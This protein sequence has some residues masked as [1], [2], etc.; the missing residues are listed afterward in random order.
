MSKLR[1]VPTKW[2]RSLITR[3]MLFRIL[4]FKMIYILCKGCCFIWGPKPIISLRSFLFYWFL[5]CSVSHISF[6][7]L[8]TYC[9]FC[10]N[11]SQLS[12]FVRVLP[13]CWVKSRLF[14]ERWHYISIIWL[15]HF[16]P[17]KN[18]LRLYKEPVV[19]MLARWGQVNRISCT[20][21]L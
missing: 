9:S 18:I 14:F 12:I 11:R 2:E 8:A 15:W 17:W 10:E 20:P 16:W 19:I 5:T 6:S 7:S 3:F 4:S 1:P 21:F 13:P